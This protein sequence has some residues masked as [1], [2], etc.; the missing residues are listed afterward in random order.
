QRG[1][2]EVDAADEPLDVHGAARPGRALQVH[3]APAGIVLRDRGGIRGAGRVERSGVAG[4]RREEGD[5]DHARGRRLEEPRP[6]DRRIV[7]GP[8]EDIGSLKRRAGATAPVRQL[9]LSNS[10]ASPSPSSSGTGPFRRAYAYDTRK[11]KM[12]IV[13]E[14]HLLSPKS[15]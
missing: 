11:I 14:N 3:R 15:T 4:A 12:M 5:E 13:N 1:S 10:S 6:E 9:R 2:G 8:L 7:S